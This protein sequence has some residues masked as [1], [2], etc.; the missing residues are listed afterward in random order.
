MLHLIYQSPI[1][2]ATLDR[3]DPGDA[4][5][6]LQD[7]LYRILSDSND[8]ERLKEKLTAKSVYVLRDELEVRGLEASR[9]IPDIKL[10]NISGLVQLTVANKTIMSWT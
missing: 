8:A 9:L 4:V 10:I 2:Q 1:K 5:V 7:S 6:F 3:I